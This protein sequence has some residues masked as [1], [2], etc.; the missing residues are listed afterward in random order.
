MVTAVTNFGRS[1]LSDWLLQRV[2]AVVLLAYTLFIAG[3]VFFGP[4]IDY[5][6]WKALFAATWMRIFSLAAVL[7]IAAHAWIGLWSVSTDY[8]T[9][10]LLGSKGNVIRL[11]FQ[12]VVAIVLFVY[13]IWGIQ[14]LWGNHG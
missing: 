11:L 12:A 3:Y 5:A 1:G 10:R 2:T 6:I 14:I 7:S 13:V 9:E 4:T 8:F